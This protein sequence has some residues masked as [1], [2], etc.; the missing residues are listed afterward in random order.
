MNVRENGT[1]PSLKTILG[2]TLKTSVFLNAG[3]KLTFCTKLKI[4]KGEQNF[5][6]HFTYV[7][8]KHYKKPDVPMMNHETE[9]FIYLF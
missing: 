3:H 1:T 9:F 7:K 6:S 4:T 5:R 8:A 2:E